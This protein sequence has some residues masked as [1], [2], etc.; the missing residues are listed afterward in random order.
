MNKK[1]RRIV[2]EYVITKNIQAN[3]TPNTIFW[4]VR[5]ESGKNRRRMT[6][7]TRKGTAVDT[8]RYFCTNTLLSLSRE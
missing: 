2:S 1:R 5:E 7:T 8:Y 3:N 4:T 6:I